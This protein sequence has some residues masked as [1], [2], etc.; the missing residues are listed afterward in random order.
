MSTGNILIIA[1]NKT[2]LEQLTHLLRS[3]GFFQI[4]YAVSTNDA[5]QKVVYLEPDIIIV[6]CPLCG[7]SRIDFIMDLSERTSSG[8]LILTPSDTLE[9]MQYDL[10][11]IGAIIIPK[12]LSRAILVDTLHFLAHFWSY[13]RDSKLSSL[14]SS[15]KEEEKLII[16]ESK[17]LLIN[18]LGLTEPCAHR[19]IQKQSMNLRLSQV[20]V[21]HQIIKY[22]S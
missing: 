21:A 7:E 6:N 2:L 17:T 19:Y 16:N 10:Q 9:D 8:L 11:H 14:S 5:R 1:S 13:R 15:S 12:P 18:K 22:F 3:E 4:E 20:K